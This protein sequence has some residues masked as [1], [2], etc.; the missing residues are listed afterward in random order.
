M[1]RLDVDHVSKV[2]AHRVKALDDISFSVDPGE[3]FSIV[4][5]TNAGKT[6]LLK[7]IAGL[8]A[9]S[10]GR[11]LLDGTDV[12]GQEPAMRRLS[13]MFQNIAL[14]P[15]KTARENIAYPLQLAGQS[16][17]AIAARVDEVAKVVNVGHLLDRLP[18][19]YSGGEQQR[20]AIAR[21][22]ARPSRILMLDEPLTNLDARLRIALRMEF[23]NLHRTT[24]Q[25]IIYVTHDQTEAMSLSDRILVLRNGRIEQIGTA[26]DIYHRPATRFVAEFIGTPP[27]NILAATMSD[28]GPVPD[29]SSVA[30]GV[31]RHGYD[32]LRGSLSVGI[33]PE[34]VTAGATQSAQNPFAGE[35]VWIE[36]LGSRSVLD[37]RIGGQAARAV[38]RP[39]HPLRQT[40]PAWF[41]LPSER[42]HLLDEPS[43]RFIRSE[44]PK[45]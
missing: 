15:T 5:P 2:F 6:T 7:L 32:T 8:H 23:R 27:M 20:V 4:G 22:I 41:G 40:G 35:V 42:V 38:V 12:T 44:N 9:T 1:S 39:D 30:I 3:F 13:L 31:R 17:D 28:H 10:S 34:H 14:F 36:R 25:T 21:A 45:H 18:Q 29:G 19:T 16:V 43:G 37:I 24:G 33:R 11:V 26:D